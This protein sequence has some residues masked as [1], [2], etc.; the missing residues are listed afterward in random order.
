MSM[1]ATAVQP[2]TPTLGWAIGAAVIIVI[3][4]HFIAKR[5]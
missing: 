3:A 2:H 1:N 5:K 4:Y